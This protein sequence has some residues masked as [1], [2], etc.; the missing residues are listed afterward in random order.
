MPKL[1]DLLCQSVNNSSDFGSD[2][3][4]RFAYNLHMDITKAQKYLALMV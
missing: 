1:A 4:V 2:W 3:Y